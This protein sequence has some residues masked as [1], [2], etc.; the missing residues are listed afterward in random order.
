M[1]E[2]NNVLDIAKDDNLYGEVITLADSTADGTFLIHH[3]LSFF[4]GNNRPL[5]HVSLTQSFGHHKSVCQKL[6]INLTQKI[7]SSHLNFFDGLKVFGN[8]FLDTQPENVDISNS[9]S[10]QGFYKA[11]KS[12]YKDLQD[13]N[14]APPVVIVDSLN[15][16]LNIGYQVN[17]ISAFVQYLCHLISEPDCGA[18][19][20][21]ITF[22]SIGE[23]GMDEEASLLWRSVVHMS[24]MDVRVSGLESGY[25]KD[26][27]GKVKNLLSFLWQI[28]LNKPKTL[29]YI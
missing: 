9:G 18:K 26:V 21:L 13:K 4:L 25:C 27:H 19:G 22:L 28:F 8:R 23:N 3:F 16:L 14:G 11:I 29:L 6:G 20:T 15:V 2:V 17:E 7:E 1:E 24:N 5:C 10:L 12:K